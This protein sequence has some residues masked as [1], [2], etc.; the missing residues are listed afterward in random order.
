MPRPIPVKTID[1]QDPQSARKDAEGKVNT[2][3]ITEHYL[4]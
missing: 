2:V 4:S 3:P 1:P